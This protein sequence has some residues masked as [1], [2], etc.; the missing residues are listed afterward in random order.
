MQAPL[1]A[2][3][4]SLKSTGSGQAAAVAAELPVRLCSVAASIETAGGVSRQRIPGRWW[5]LLGATLWTNLTHGHGITCVRCHPGWQ[6]PVGPGWGAEARQL[7]L[8][9]AVPSCCALL[10][11]HGA[12][13]LFSGAAEG[14][15]HS[16]WDGPG[17]GALSMPETGLVSVV[18]PVAGLGW[19]GPAGWHGDGLGHCGRDQ[20]SSSV[21]C[22]KWTDLRPREAVP[23]P[24]PVTPKWAVPTAQALL[25]CLHPRMHTLLSQSLLPPVRRL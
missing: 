8:R 14:S 21:P 2:G 16:A 22:T 24:I 5:G 15:F 18:T 3:V 7:S 20:S 23:V 17:L 11:I 9:A 1:G 13:A 12:L 25:P 10:L 19:T 4:G 6:R